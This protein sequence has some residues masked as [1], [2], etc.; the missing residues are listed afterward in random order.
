MAARA[1]VLT[2]SDWAPWTEIITAGVEARW[3]LP[4]LEH[5][6]SLFFFFFYLLCP[7]VTTIIFLQELAVIHLH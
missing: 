1:S 6:F 3:S 4:L 5:L 7:V 2:A